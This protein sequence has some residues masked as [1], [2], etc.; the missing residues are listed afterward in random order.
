MHIVCM[1][2]DVQYRHN[3][4]CRLNSKLKI[5]FFG[6]GALFFSLK[7]ENAIIAD[8]NPELINMYLQVAKACGPKCAPICSV[9]PSGLA[10]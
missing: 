2:Y 3:A 1:V 8:S 10:A 5:T 6:G 4:Q 7:P 9:K